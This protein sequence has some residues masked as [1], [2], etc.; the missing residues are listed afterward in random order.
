MIQT[1]RSQYSYTHD[2]N[3]KPTGHSRKGGKTA[4]KK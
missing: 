3:K 4:F 1:E 2:L